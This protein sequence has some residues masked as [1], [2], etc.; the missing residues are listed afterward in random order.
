MRNTSASVAPFD[1][2]GRLGFNRG[3]GGRQPARSEMDTPDNQGPHIKGHRV[4]FPAGVL[5][6][7]GDLDRSVVQPSHHR[8]QV[9]VV[10][11]SGQTMI[12]VHITRGQ[13]RKPSRGGVA[14]GPRARPR[15]RD[16]P[17]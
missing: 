7:V 9:R 3:A 5:C 6:S 1:Y 11:G 12:C 8:Q 10:H 2:G 4:A 16:E 13:A 14:R 15:R 17:E